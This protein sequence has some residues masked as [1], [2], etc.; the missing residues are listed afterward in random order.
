MP[1]VPSPAQSAKIGWHAP[2]FVRAPPVNHVTSRT[3]GLL[4]LGVKRLR[5]DMDGRNCATG[6]GAN[7]ATSCGA[8]RPVSQQEPSNGTIGELIRELRKIEIEIRE[9]GLQG[10]AK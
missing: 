5:I 9:F 3:S 8:I 10:E 2:W 4:R 7:C 1:Q 6:Y